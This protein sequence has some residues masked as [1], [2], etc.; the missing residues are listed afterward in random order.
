MWITL[1]VTEAGTVVRCSRLFTNGAK[2][3]LVKAIELGRWGEPM[4]RTNRNENAAVGCNKCFTAQV[5]REPIP[6]DL[7]LSPPICAIQSS[8]V[9][10][11]GMS[12]PRSVVLDEELLIGSDE[13]L[14]DSSNFSFLYFWSLIFF[15]IVSLWS[16]PPTTVLFGDDW[17]GLTDDLLGCANA[18]Q[19]F[20]GRLIANAIIPTTGHTIYSLMWC[21]INWPRK[22]QPK[23]CMLITPVRFWCTRNLA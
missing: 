18:S 5:I 9:S 8:L 21:S 17:W 2:T 6:C 20:S 13:W 22:S 19:L 4:K 7:S 16:A 12:S 3:A 14:F 1:T 23:I 11:S 15:N 10:S